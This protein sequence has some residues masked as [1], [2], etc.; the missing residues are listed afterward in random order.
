M[1]E[2]THSCL[3]STPTKGVFKQNDI[4]HNVSIHY[5]YGS[6]HNKYESTLSCLESTPTG[7]FFFKQ[8][9]ILQCI[10]S[11]TYVLTRSNLESVHVR[12]L[13]EL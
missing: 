12:Y 2:S 7:D 9:F 10:D 1:N 4:A 11:H 8:T 13:I 3:E 5:G 6:I